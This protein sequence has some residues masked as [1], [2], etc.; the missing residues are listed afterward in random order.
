[1][2]I[3][4]YAAW[5]AKVI[6]ARR[7]RRAATTEE[8]RMRT[9]RWL[10]CMACALVPAA[11]WA[12]AWPARPVKIVVPFA[13]GGASD[14]LARLVGQRLAARLGQPFVVENRPGAATTIGAAE[15]ARAPADGYTL[16]LAPAPFVIASLMYPSLTY[17]PGDFTGIALIATSPLIL[18]ANVSIP[19]STVPELLALA[20]AKPGTLS[21]ASPGNG[22]VPHLATELFKTR[23]GADL[24]HIPYKGGGPA[25][26][27]LVAGHVGLMFASP[28]EV[29]QFVAAGKLRYIATS[30][31]KRVA[32]L[33]GVPT[34]AEYGIPDFDVV[35]WF[36]IVAPAATP[37]PVVARLSAEIGE[38]LQAP[39]IREKFS[40]QGADIQFMPA[41]EFDRFLA[42]E[43]EQWAQAIKVSG[44]KIE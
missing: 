26:N 34:V 18:T 32:S 5:A 35:A 15:V 9:A 7:A 36:G 16:M 43:R 44:A 17:A 39:D 38:I 6:S 8:L 3:D 19:A 27:D 24:T 12:Q 41:A 40:V 33:P 11:A 29:S 31:G 10:L 21:Y 14:V 37:K 13:P 25:V 30:T 1:M 4:E 2:M 20:R 22:S 23:T 42:R 28:I